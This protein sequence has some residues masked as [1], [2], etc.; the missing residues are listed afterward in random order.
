VG[1]FLTRRKHQS[2]GSGRSDVMRLLHEQVEPA[3]E[4]SAL[5]ELECRREVFRWVAERVRGTVSEA[6]WQAFWQSS[7]AARPIAEVARDLKMSV[8]SVYI[9]R[10][11]VMAKLRERATQKSALSTTT[12]T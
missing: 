7:V 8:G 5:F 2:M 1:N 6:T 11:R 12:L 4:A 3:G 10:S 9:A